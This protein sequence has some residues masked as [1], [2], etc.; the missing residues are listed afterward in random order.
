M[1]TTILILLLLISI[2]LV[3]AVNRFNEK[4]DT[5]INDLEKR[6]EVYDKL[7]HT[8]N[9]MLEEMDDK[10]T[11]LKKQEAEPKEPVSKP[12]PEAP[13]DASNLA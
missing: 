1:L 12:E 13:G 9:N 3:I 7:F 11:A 2:Y 10:L 6:L 8:Q 5:R 4:F